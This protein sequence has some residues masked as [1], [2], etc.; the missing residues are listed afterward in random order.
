MA[1]TDANGQALFTYDALVSLEGLGTDEIQACFTDDLGVVAC[2]TAQ[3]EWVD[4]TPPEARCE[5]G[6]NP[7]GK[8]I[9]KSKNPDGFYQ[10]FAEDFLD[11]DPLVFIQ[12][13]GSSMIFPGPEG[14]SVGTKIK[15]TEAPGTTPKM[16]KM[17]SDNGHGIIIWHILGNGDA[18]LYATDVSGN[19]S[20]CVYCR[21]PPPPK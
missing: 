19:Q 15:Y 13:S 7:S 8:N 11:P 12:D 14:F 20:D 3:K 6:T 1:T 5:E 17:G 2:D 9:P 18:C 4:E 21:V 16:Q 10:L